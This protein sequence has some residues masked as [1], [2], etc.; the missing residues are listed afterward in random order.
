MCPRIYIVLPTE[1]RNSEKNPE[2]EIK[3]IKKHSRV[4]VVS[5]NF[6]SPN[7]VNDTIRDPW[8]GRKRGS[9]KEPRLPVWDAKWNRYSLWIIFSDTSCVH[10]LARATE[11]RPDRLT[12]SRASE[13]DSIRP[14]GYCWPELTLSS[15]S[16]RNSKFALARRRADTRVALRPSLPH[17]LIP[18]PFFTDRI[19]YF[20]WSVVRSFFPSAVPVRCRWKVSDSFDRW[21]NGAIMHSA[22]F[23]VNTERTGY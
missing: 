3:G 11:A 2:R 7:D 12:V 13:Q 22:L 1:I 15:G 10:S 16:E 9:R 17:P 5:R 23:A 18:T 19:Y 20:S 14:G 21:R 8:S 4:S 6:T